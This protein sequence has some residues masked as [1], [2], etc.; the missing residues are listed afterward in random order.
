MSF[1][2]SALV[3]FGLLLALLVRSGS[4][5]GGGALVAVLFGYYLSRTGFSAPIDQF[6]TT[7]SKDIPT[8]K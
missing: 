4:V 2:V 6:M 1:S 5:K 7:L 8:F 3:L